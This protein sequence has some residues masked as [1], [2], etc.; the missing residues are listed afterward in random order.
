MDVNHL[1]EL[2]KE[3]ESFQR[4]RRRKDITIAGTV[5]FIES[6]IAK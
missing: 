1:S 5:V 6:L 2:L 3:T 4:E